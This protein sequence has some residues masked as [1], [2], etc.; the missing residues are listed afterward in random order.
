MKS[1]Y[2]LK[3]VAGFLLALV[4]FAVSAISQSPLTRNI[5]F[6]AFAFL[7]LVPYY[8]RCESCGWVLP[9]HLSNPDK[10][11]FEMLNLS[12]PLFQGSCP[13]CGMDRL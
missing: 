8:V 13:K 6:V 11:W 7:A 9:Q 10:N 3:I 2:R 5:A 1:K 12:K 4:P